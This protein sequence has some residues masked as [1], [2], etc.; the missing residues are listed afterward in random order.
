MNLNKPKAIVL[1]VGP[2][3]GLGGALCKRFANEGHHVFVGGR[4]IDKLENIVRIIESQSGSA[5]AVACD[6]T[7]EEDVKSLFETAKTTGDGDLNLAVYN[8]GNSTPGNIREMDAAFFEKTWRIL[9]F[10]GFL[11]GKECTRYLLPKGGTLVFTGASASLRGKSGFGAFNSGKAALRTLAQAMAKEYGA[12]GLHVGHVIIDGGIAGDKWFSRIGA[13]PS[14][15]EMER[16]ISLDALTD[17]YW[18]LHQQK[19]DG[20]SFEID[21]RT[22]IENW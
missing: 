5:T 12:E 13:E 18:T 15:D 11:F 3:R 1:G 19:R 8:V 7:R 2:E 17:A 20:W 14:K 16:F 6:A 22:A 21:L 10:G 4:S 9:C